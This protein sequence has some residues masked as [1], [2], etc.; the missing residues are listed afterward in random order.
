MAKNKEIGVVWPSENFA[1]QDIKI[2]NINKKIS[3]P[4]LKGIPTPLTKNRSK[5]SA[6]ETIFGMIIF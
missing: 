2:K 1:S 4:E 5:E 6:N 3:A